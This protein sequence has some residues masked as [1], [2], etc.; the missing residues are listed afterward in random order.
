MFIRLYSVCRFYVVYRMVLPQAMCPQISSHIGITS[1]EKAD[2]A[3][4]SALNIITI[5]AYPLQYPVLWY[6]I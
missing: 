6:H 4:K 2:Q 3:A 5:T 1:N